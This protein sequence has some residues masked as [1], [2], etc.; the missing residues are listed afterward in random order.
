MH[1]N[2]LSFD[3]NKIYKFYGLIKT[4]R[5]DFGIDWNEYELFGHKN[6]LNGMKWIVNH[7]NWMEIVCEL[8]VS[9][10]ICIETIELNIN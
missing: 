9:N 2:S 3:V 10:L 1:K 7:L 5:I 6:E 8:V 4:N